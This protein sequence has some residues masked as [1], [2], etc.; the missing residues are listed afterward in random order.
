M[1]ARFAVPISLLLTLLFTLATCAV[2]EEQNITVKNEFIKLVVNRGPNEAGRFSVDT[3]GGDPTRPTSKDQQLIYGGNTPWTSFT[4]VR[5]D[6]TNNV[7][8]GKTARRAGL[9]ANYGDAVSGPTVTDNGIT[10]VYK[11]GD[12]LVSQELVFVRGV[13]SRMLDTVGITYR[14]SNQGQSSHKVGL[15]LM[16]DTKLGPNDGAPM[17]VGT[18]AITSA[19]LIPDSD[20]SS[21]WQAFDSLDNPTVVSQGT[22][23]GASSNSTKPDKVIFSDW[24]TLADDVW[25]PTLDPRLGFHRKGEWDPDQDTPGD[26]D[27]LDT[28]T[29]LFWSPIAIE[30]GKSVSYS[31]NYGIGYMNVNKGALSVGITAPAETTFEYERTQPI[32]VTG[33]LKNQSDFEGRNVKLTLKLPEGLKL[34]SG[35]PATQTVESFKP[36]AELQAS[37]IIVPTGK[38]SGKVT[39]KLEASSDNME[40]NQAAWDIQVNV[41]KPRLVLSPNAQRIILPAK[42]KPVVVPIRIN[43][44][45]AVEFYGTRLTLTYDP[46]ML[47]LMSFSPVSRGTAFVEDNRLLSGWECD[48]S[49]DGKI[50]ITAN[51]SDSSKLTQAE[52]N[53][54]TVTFRAIGTGKSQLTLENAVLINEKGEESPVATS[55]G[56]VEI[57]ATPVQ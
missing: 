1:L 25:E 56:Q 29:A 53:L 37:W 41:P 30:P 31:T 36:G 11:Y 17:R 4:T 57:Q 38:V 21:Y 49:E 5:V 40:S 26:D 27:E 15:R 22:L 52:I 20:L 8:G 55:A 43:L 24:G 46:T 19:T 16:L 34:D 47:K 10:T 35:S 14:I 48:T 18:Q 45:P 23:Y 54:A 6:D 7:F 32:T 12:V 42:G 2:A 28:A 9:N 13:S 33:Y 44:S 39:V 50:V 3:T 51:R